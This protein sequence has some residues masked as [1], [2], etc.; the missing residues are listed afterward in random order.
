MRVSWVK[1]F[2]VVFET[3]P[4]SEV[5]KGTQSVSV[6]LNPNLEP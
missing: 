3:L 6:D 2:R 1:G 4:F 5:L